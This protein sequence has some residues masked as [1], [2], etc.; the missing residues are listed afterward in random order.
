[1]IVYLLTLPSFYVIGVFHQVVLL[2]NQSTSE[3]L[4]QYLHAILKAVST[5]STRLWSHFDMVVKCAITAPR[6]AQNSTI[7]T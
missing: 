4:Q 2:V 6:D 3:I 7:I 5:K 1:M